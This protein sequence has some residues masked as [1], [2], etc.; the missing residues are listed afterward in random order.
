MT[1]TEHIKQLL[2]QGRK[3]RELIEFGF[4]KRDVT[5]AQRQLRKERAISRKK[6]PEEAPQAETQLQTPPESPETIATIWLNVNS[7][8]KWKEKFYS[9]RNSSCVHMLLSNIPMRANLGAC[10]R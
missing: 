1:I 9:E 6:E 4:K 8:R 7:Q 5:R 10:Q 2:R 3:R